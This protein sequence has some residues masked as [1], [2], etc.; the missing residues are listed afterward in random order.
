MIKQLIIIYWRI[1]LFQETPEN[2]PY[3]PILM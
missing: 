2:T 1:V 3:S